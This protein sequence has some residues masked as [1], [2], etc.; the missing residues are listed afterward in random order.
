MRLIIWDAIAPIITHCNASIVRRN[1]MV[2]LRW[3]WVYDPS[4]SCYLY[5]WWNWPMV[6]QFNSERNLPF[7]VN[8]TNQQFYPLQMLE[9]S[10][11]ILAIR[12]AS[13]TICV[14]SNVLN[15]WILSESIKLRLTICS[16]RHESSN[17]HCRTRSKWP[18]CCKHHFSACSWHKLFIV[19][20]MY[21]IHMF[22]W[23]TFKCITIL[24]IS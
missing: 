4:L 21:H 13:F 14:M 17:G 8:D 7:V 9:S 22:L 12:C 20:L 18:T 5:T 16:T 2:P 10:I 19:R 11:H 23:S 24:N 1:P 6:R 3:S 15:S